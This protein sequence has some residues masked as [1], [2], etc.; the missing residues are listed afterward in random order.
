MT[1]EW[2]VCV[3]LVYNNV[4][5]ACVCPELGVFVDDLQGFGHQVLG[6]LCAA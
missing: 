5:V 6:L 3:Y 4:V 1:T 2:S